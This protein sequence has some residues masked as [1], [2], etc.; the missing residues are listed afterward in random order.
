MA[1]ATQSLRRVPPLAYHVAG[2]VQSHPFVILLIHFRTGPVSAG[3]RSNARQLASCVSRNA[4]WRLQFGMATMCVVT[5]NEF[6]LALSHRDNV[7][8]DFQVT[9]NLPNVTWPLARNWAGNIP[10]QRPGHPNDT[11]FF[12][13]FESSN[14]SFT[15][16]SNEPWGIW[17]NGGSVH[18]CAYVYHTANVLCSPGAS[19]LLGLLFEVRVSLVLFAL[20]I[21]HV[22]LRQALSISW[23]IIRW[24]KINMHGLLLPITCGSTNQCMSVF[25]SMWKW[26]LL[27]TTAEL[28]SV[29]STPMG[30][31]S[32]SSYVLAL[33]V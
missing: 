9:E 20:T 32:T 2:S 31:V 21:I 27:F 29:L 28:D 7:L 25:S 1:L 22:H 17:L 3:E 18:K 16:D 15:A 11:L 13:A 12:W 10:V 23:L 30:S 19:S 33:V 4:D 14:G 26:I 8:A 24:S 6:T 5:W